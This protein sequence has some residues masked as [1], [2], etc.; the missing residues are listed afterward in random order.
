MLSWLSRPLEAGSTEAE[1]EEAEKQ[2][3]Y[4]TSPFPIEP[5]WKKNEW[6]AGS[7]TTVIKVVPKNNWRLTE[8]EEISFAIVYS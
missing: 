3:S 6:L 2:E 7:A 1:A 8:T 4:N 5:R